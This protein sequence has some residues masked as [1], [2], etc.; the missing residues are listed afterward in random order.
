MKDMN[1]KEGEAATDAAPAARVTSG[2]TIDV[3]A[4]EKTSTGDKSGT[5][6]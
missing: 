5:S 6:H 1:A 4:K 2:E 3:Q